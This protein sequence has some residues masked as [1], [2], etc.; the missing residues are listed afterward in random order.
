M[1]SSERAPVY[2][3]DEND[4]VCFSS[5]LAGVAFSAGVIHAYL[6][7][8]RKPPRVVAGISVGAL[9]AA[10]MQRCYQELQKAK[11]DAVAP[12]GENASRIEAGRWEWFRRYVSFLLD[13]PLDVIWNCIPDPTDFL[14]ELPPVQEPALPGGEKRAQWEQKDIEARRL[15]WIY[16]RLGRWLAHLGITVKLMATLLVHWVRWQERYPRRYWVLSGL[17]L[18]AY[19]PVLVLRLAVHFFFRPLFIREGMFPVKVPDEAGDRPRHFRPLFGWVIWLT[20][21]LYLAV[22]LAPWL[23]VAGP[24][25]SYTRLSGRNFHG[26]GWLSRLRS[27]GPCQPSYSF[28]PWH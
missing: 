16:V 4:A 7:A 21:G 23:A 24:P 13:R 19:V 18:A 14:A 15:L 25:P 17:R 2:S 26:Y 20:A 27:C 10:A 8:D 3:S 5:G 1:E 9:S 22:V 28:F 12:D 6:A 11:R